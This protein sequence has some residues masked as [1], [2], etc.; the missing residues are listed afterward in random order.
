MN[1]RSDVYQ[2]QFGEFTIDQADRLSVIV[3]RGALAIAALCF[4]I[5]A[6]LVPLMIVP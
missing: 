3:Y 2:G 6:I 4:S 5:G 1:I